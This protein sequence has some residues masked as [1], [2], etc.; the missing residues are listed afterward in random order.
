MGLQLGANAGNIQ[1]NGIPADNFRSR[2]A[3]VFAANAISFVANEINFDN[4]TL[5]APN[6]R[7][8]L[9]AAAEWGSGIRRTKRLATHNG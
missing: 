1:V 5:S 6:G 9:W 7:V 8:Q 4:S 2:P 3:Q